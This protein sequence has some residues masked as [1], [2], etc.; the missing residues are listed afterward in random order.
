MELRKKLVWSRQS[1][2]LFTRLWR[3]GKAYKDDSDPKYEAPGGYL[4]GFVAGALLLFMFMNFGWL[5]SDIAP[6]GAD[7]SAIWLR[8][9]R[10]LGYVLYL[11]VGLVLSFNALGPVVGRIFRR[12]DSAKEV[13]K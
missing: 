7:G 9:V 5:G 13:T 12:I 2:E 4:E 8:L 6:N 10:V 3:S 11:C 1:R